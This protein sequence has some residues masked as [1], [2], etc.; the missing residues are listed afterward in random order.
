M[1]YECLHFSLESIE[2]EEYSIEPNE[3][4]EFSLESIKSKDDS[5]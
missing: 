4:L 1:N 5:I 2:S 3:S